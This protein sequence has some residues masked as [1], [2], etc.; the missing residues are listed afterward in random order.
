MGISFQALLAPA[1][2]FS[3][4]SQREIRTPQPLKSRVLYEHPAPIDE[5]GRRFSAWSGFCDLALGKSNSNFL[6]KAF[7]RAWNKVLP[8]R[9]QSAL[10]RID[11]PSRESC[12]GRGALM[13]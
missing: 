6:W 10:Q 8:R 5:R 11:P 13:V 4:A 12:E 3:A 1:F 9:S 7:G 2:N